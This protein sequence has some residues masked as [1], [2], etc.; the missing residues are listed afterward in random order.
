V[1]RAARRWAPLLLAALLA[2]CGPGPRA[3]LEPL[4]TLHLEPLTK[5][6]ARRVSLERE[7]IET[8]L[9]DPHSTDA[10][11][12]E[13]FG[14][15][16]TLAFA[17]ELIRPGMVCY[18]N[19]E[20]LAPHDK[21]WPYYLGHLGRFSGDV[22]QSLRGF[23]RAL[24]LDPDDRATLFHLGELYLDLE[25]L[26]DAESIYRRAMALGDPSGSVGL[27]FVFLERDDFA[28][29]REQF[30]SAL[31]RVP[32]AGRL[33]YHLGM[34]L[35]RLGD[36]EGARAHMAQQGPGL[37]RPA[38]PPMDAVLALREELR[39][40]RSV[41]D[42]REA[43][44]ADSGDPAARLRLGTAL[45][46]EGKLDEAEGHFRAAL[47]MGGDPQLVRTANLNL[48]FL[49][50]DRGSPDEAAGYYARVLE[51]DAP[52]GGPAAYLELARTLLQTRRFVSARRVYERGRQALPTDAT[53]ANAYAMLLAT[54]PD[55]T[56]RDGP[57]AL[58]LA[59]SL[60]SAMKN[61]PQA[62]TLAAAL[63]ENGRFEEAAKL[64]R[65]ALAEAEKLGRPDLT[66][67]LR[68]HL[69]LYESGRP[70]RLP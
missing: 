12:A 2:G 61:G 1:S 48:G 21:R 34:I 35:A 11:L 8:L 30:E 4:P 13:A 57:A 54:C 32:D 46:N 16:G 64:Q 62:A 24:E 50:D 53:I 3:R 55:D 19:A 20:R 43:G 25:R 14:D 28:A 59:S 41:D 66:P 18:R 63:A 7:R 5:P 10:D 15:L 70:L 29:A 33:H 38:D 37:P 67:R 60:F 65:G 23:E 39:T 42:L 47:Q 51:H 31:A 68:E 58:G 9:A 36:M 27:G 44:A 17:T 45:A 52:T 69:A 22:E 56:V 26:D 40:V 49:L 6:V